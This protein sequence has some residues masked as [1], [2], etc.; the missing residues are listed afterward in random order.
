MASELAMES[1][2]EPYT[3]T[4]PFA[5][6]MAT[7]IALQYILIAFVGIIIDTGASRKSIAGYS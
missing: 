5:Y 1:A 7:A 2:M 4:D 3:E 6:N